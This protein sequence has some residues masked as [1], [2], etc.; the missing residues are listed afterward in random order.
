MASFWCSKALGHV[1]ERFDIEVHAAE[2]ILEL[3]NVF[4]TLSNQCWNHVLRSIDCSACFSFELNLALN[5]NPLLNHVDQLITGEGFERRNS[6]RGPAI[7]RHNCN[8][9]TKGEHFMGDFSARKFNHFNDWASKFFLHSCR[10]FDRHTQFENL[11]YLSRF[12]V[13]DGVKNLAHKPQFHFSNE[14]LNGFKCG[15]SVSYA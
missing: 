8:F 6:S 7:D 5:T 4:S 10:R 14:P 12:N 13:N 3:A 9:R 1:F 15:I 11:L 2:F